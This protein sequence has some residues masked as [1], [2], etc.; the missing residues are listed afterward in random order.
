[1][2]NPPDSGLP[3]VAMYDTTTIVGVVIDKVTGL[4]W[5]RVIDPGS[6]MPSDAVTYCA[7]L[8]LAGGCWRLPTRIELVS[9]VDFTK[10][11]SGSTIDSVAFPDTPGTAFGTSSPLAG[12]PSG[13]WGVNFFGGNTGYSDVSNA[14]RVRCVR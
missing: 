2:P 3:N 13:A 6:Y 4:Q 8:A 5:Q 9:L 14:F 10:S 11:S 12:S 7:N 1:M